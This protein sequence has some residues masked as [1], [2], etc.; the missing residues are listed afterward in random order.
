M[1]RQDLDSGPLAQVSNLFQSHPERG[2]WG[3]SGADRDGGDPGISWLAGREPRPR[4]PLREGCGKK[5]PYIFELRNSK[6]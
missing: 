1:F 3:E 2:V 6:E 5:G 4:C